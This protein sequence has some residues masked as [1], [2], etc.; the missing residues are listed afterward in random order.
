MERLD[1]ANLITP[2]FYF[3]TVKTDAARRWNQLEND[4]D[5]AAPWYQLF[6]QVQSP[7][8]VISELLQNADDAGATE[9]EVQITDGTFVFSHNGEDFTEEH[10]RSLCRFGYS[11]K[12]SLHTIGF[13]GV[14]F[15][16]IFSLG[17]PVYL[18]T[19]TLAVAFYSKRFTEPVWL[20]N[21][22]RNNSRTIIKV[23]IQNEHRR[24]ELDKNIQEWKNSPA[25]LLFFRSIRCLK[26]NGSELRWTYLG[27]GPLPNS[28]RMNYSDEPNREYLLFRSELEEFPRQAL[29]E[30]RNE[31]LLPIT[32]KTEFPPCRVEIV[33]GLEG[34]LFVVLPTGVTT[35]LPFA[36]NAPFVQD[37]AR[38]KIKDP[39]ISFTNR[40]LL[41]R[42]GKLA[43]NSMLAWVRRQDLST[44]ERCQAYS[45]LPYITKNESSLDATCGA[46]VGEA[47]LA[48]LSGHKFIIT[49]NNELVEPGQ[50]V[51]VPNSILEVWTPEEV[52]ELCD[53]YKRPILHSNIHDANRKKLINLNFCTT[54]DKSHLTSLLSHQYP[55]KPAS[56][57]QLVN[58]WAYLFD[59]NNWR[60]I[61]TGHYKKLRIVPVVGKQILFS[62]DEVVRM[63]L[64]QR[65]LQP[66]D[67]D[68][69]SNL[70]LVVEP[71]WIRYLS[72]QNSQ[73][74][75]TSSQQR[76]IV[77][78]QQLLQYTGLHETTD[79][80]KL[81][82]KACHRLIDTEEVT[83]EE[84]IRL[85]HIAARLDVKIKN[86]FYYMNCN[87]EIVQADKGLVV[88]LNQNLDLYTP[89]DWYNSNVLHEAYSTDFFACT[90]DEWEYWAS[91][92]KSKLMQFVYP[93]STTRSIWSRRAIHKLLEKR[94]Y[95]GVPTFHY[96]R[97][98]FILEDWDF[99]P[100]LWS[101]WYKLAKQDET[102]WV[103]IMTI[104]L[105][106]PIKHWSPRLS[107]TIWHK[108]TTYK[109]PVTNST[110]LPAWLLKFKDLKCL[111]DTRG[112]SCLPCE[113]LL[114]TPQTEALL[115]TERFVGAELDNEQTRPILQML[116]VRSS[117]T[118]P[119][120]IISRIQALSQAHTPPLYELEK[121]Y[122]RL[123][124]LYKYCSTKERDYLE[125]AFETA[126]L[127][128]TEGE[129]WASS[130]EVCLDADDTWPPAA[131]V[132]HRFRALNLWNEIGV[133]SY[134][135][136]SWVISW[137][138]QIESETQLTHDD[139]DKIQPFLRHYGEEIW[140]ACQHWIS[141]DGTWRP[142][143]Q[144]E[145]SLN[146]KNFPHLDQ[147]FPI[148]KEQTADIRMLS[149]NLIPR[150]PF[151]RLPEL[152][153]SVTQQ[154]AHDAIQAIRVEHKSWLSTLGELLSRIVCGDPEETLKI[155]REASRLKKTSLNFTKRLQTILYLNGTQVSLPLS[156][157]AFWQGEKLYIVNRRIAEVYS[158]IAR[159]LSRP[160]GR[161]D[162]SDAIKSCIAR[163]PEFIIEYIE[164]NFKLTPVVTSCPGDTPDGEGRQDLSEQLPESSASAIQSP[165]IDEQV[166]EDLNT[167]SNSEELLSSN[168]EQ[169]EQ[170]DKPETA[171][172]AAATT[173]N[174]QHNPSKPNAFPSQASQAPSLIERFALQNGYT[175]L[176][177]TLFVGPDGRRL[178]RS[179]DEANLWEY[180]N[181]KGQL[182]HCY[183]VKEHCLQKRPL[184][185]S[186][187]V[188]SLTVKYPHQYSFVL[189]DQDN[190]PIVYSGIWLK[191]QL[192]EGN[193]LLFP[194]SYR[195]SYRSS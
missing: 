119:E 118:G 107:A 120:G 167:I 162:I 85:T 43:A 14:G 144:F 135:S 48:T 4:P 124:Q 52:S 91:S 72:E 114:R 45:L 138:K 73:P 87:Q 92:R 164:S 59:I 105:Q 61:Y 19:P 154:L 163:S 90:A 147:I 152:S 113:L 36:C 63:A 80:A 101:H 27:K 22:P 129:T 75:T 84:F 96:K 191:E 26:V 7:R 186:A 155:K 180:H 77:K 160:F 24:Q 55:P 50:C 98:D 116:G 117:P 2:P 13:R 71:D 15:K 137:L 42:I 69:L 100:E 83:L 158:A 32:D 123:D 159:E 56:Y 188:W 126:K 146:F 78:A 65:T 181:Q 182:Q 20:T 166:N 35:E 60:Y 30:I 103:N 150:S 102:I 104:I 10:F 170:V 86:D 130:Q 11:N 177:P 94:G 109:K 156:A 169:A 131:I 18:Y 9:A 93:Q 34:R 172:S 41:Q 139:R 192:T 165:Q 173:S 185:V 143:S 108:G 39:E 95:D 38:L 99:H 79:P 149:P 193:L 132:H 44:Q 68:F 161:N 29:D 8:H 3:E 176:G 12:R 49:E 175:K 136:V 168:Y 194:A 142:I 25:S 145:Y 33:L 171:S 115:G 179:E 51:A 62:A 47:F 106:Q 82:H 64:K 189:I 28:Y 122:H 153:S 5:L 187:A 134:P 37:P 183:W 58:L 54:V 140:S 67:W 66:A 110:L 184:N 195:L 40:W 190:N 6:K 174:F 97:D 111:P 157:Q 128:F 53:E 88:D 76:R 17:D 125:D 148:V 121:W 112:Y 127:I 151:A 23:A 81:V 21:S 1:Y 89:K 46:L 178:C 31:R 74:S 57:E 133:T 16:S 70:L 141:L